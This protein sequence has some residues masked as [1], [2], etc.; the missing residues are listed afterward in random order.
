MDTAYD[1]AMWSGFCIGKK[2]RKLEFTVTTLQ[3]LVPMVFALDHQN[4]ARWIPIFIRDMEEVIKVFWG[5]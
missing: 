5:M 2:T 3:K 4:Y 1:L